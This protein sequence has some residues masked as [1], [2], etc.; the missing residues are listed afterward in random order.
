MSTPTNVDDDIDLDS[1]VE[2]DGS[3]A[4]R[5]RL[6]PPL[7]STSPRGRALSRLAT[8]D[9]STFNVDLGRRVGAVPGG[10]GVSVPDEVGVSI[11]ALARFQRPPVTPDTE[12]S[13]IRR[14][15]SSQ[16]E[17]YVAV[18]LEPLRQAT[19]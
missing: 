13:T 18:P 15:H 16:C 9:R 8:Q 19:P 4:I 14:C 10:R 5:R 7:T 17:V 3:E 6:T 11:L 12:I 1:N 2:L